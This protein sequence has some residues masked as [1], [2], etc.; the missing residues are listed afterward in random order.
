MATDDQYMSYLRGAGDGVPAKVRVVKKVL[1]TVAGSTTISTSVVLPAGADF[2][3]IVLDTPVAITNAPTSCLF[4]AGTAAAGQQVV[5]D[6]DAKAQG[7]ISTTIVA[8]LDKGAVAALS[9]TTIYLAM[10]TIGASAAGTIEC[11]VEY[12]APVF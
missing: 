4:R 6:V 8:S 10:T 12:D 2:R 5:A 7:H 3:N 1:F 9:N 11:F